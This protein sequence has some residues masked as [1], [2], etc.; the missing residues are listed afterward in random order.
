MPECG[1]QCWLCDLPIR[2][3]TYKGCTHACKYCFVQRKGDLTDIDFGETT[4]ALLP[5][6]QGKRTKE[7]NWADWDIPLHWG[8]MSDP[9]QP[10]ERKY[11]RSLEC[12]KVLAETQYPVIISTNGRLCVESPWIDYLERCNVV[13]QISALCSRYD[14]LEP[15]APSF[16]ER[17]R[18]IRT[19][20]GRVQRVIVRAQPYVHDI[21]AD[22]LENIPRF[23][24]AGAHGVIFEGMKFARKKPG[25]VKLGADW[26]QPD[27]VLKHDFEAFK[28]KCHD[29]GIKFY[30][31]ENRL[32]AMGDNLTCCGVDGLDDF[33]PNV[34]NLNHIVNGDFTKPTP[35][36]LTIGT[37]RCFTASLQT[38]AGNQFCNKQSFASMML[39]YLKYKRDI[40]MAV[41]GK[42]S[43]RK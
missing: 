12:L 19:L 36:Q 43:I 39:W 30:A 28:R 25:M 40:V 16:E 4:K 7:T 38:T 17:L 35:A 6:I 10:C 5:F 14:P 41:F 37:A 18:M 22:M 3:D 9:F 26:V 42:K 24:E 32:R 27:F 13:M 8:G 21:Y 23:A 29:C 1:S 11:Q 20:S 34:Y 31:G 2:F 15:G 33:R